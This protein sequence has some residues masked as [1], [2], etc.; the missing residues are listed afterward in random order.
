MLNR[1]LSALD[2][3]LTPR[4]RSLAV[5]MMLNPLTARISLLSSGTGSVFSDSIVMSVSW[6]SLGTRVSSSTRT[7]LPAVIP[8]MTGLGTTASSVGPLASSSA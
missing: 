4:S 7:I 5:A 3:S 8:R 1:R 6:T 2:S